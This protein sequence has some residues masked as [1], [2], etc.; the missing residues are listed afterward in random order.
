MGAERDQR[1][2]EAAEDEPER[3]EPVS[4]HPGPYDYPR[5]ICQ[6]CGEECERSEE[7]AVGWTRRGSLELWCY[8]SKCDVSTFHPIPA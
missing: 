2:G 6:M 7:V 1:R 4:L 3:P 5:S 8:C